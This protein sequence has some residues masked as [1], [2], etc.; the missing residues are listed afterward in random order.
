MDCNQQGRKSTYLVEDTR[1]EFPFHGKTHAQVPALL[2]KLKA[3]YF[4]FTEQIHK[5]TQKPPNL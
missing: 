2:K 1:E 4:K 3:I 5:K